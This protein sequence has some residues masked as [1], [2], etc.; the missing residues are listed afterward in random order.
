MPQ[1]RFADHFADLEFFILPP[2]GIRAVRAGLPMLR[3]LLVLLGDYRR[4][5][6]LW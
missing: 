6:D 5:D 1:D 4:C 3:V 2:R